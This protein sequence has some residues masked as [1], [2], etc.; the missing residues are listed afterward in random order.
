MRTNQYDATITLARI[1][2]QWRIADIEILQ[3]Q[4]VIASLAPESL[5]PES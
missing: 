3:E 4:R 1:G 2:G 5:R